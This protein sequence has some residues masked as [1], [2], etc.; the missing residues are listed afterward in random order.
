MEEILKALDEAHGFT[1]VLKEYCNA[2]LEVEEIYCAAF[3][4]KRIFDIVDLSY[5]KLERLSKKED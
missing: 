5:V 3:L 2:N 4:V 1:Y